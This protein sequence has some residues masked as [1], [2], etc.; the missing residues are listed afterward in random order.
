M[1]PAGERPS[2]TTVGLPGGI[3]HALPFDPAWCLVIED[4]T[5]S[6]GAAESQLCLADGTLGT[7]A[8]L[9]DD[10]DPSVPSVVVAGIYEPAEVVVERLMP[11][12]SWTSLPLVAGLPAGRRVLDLRDGTLRRD[13]EV[14]GQRLHSVRFA[15]LDL[16]GSAVLVAD[17]DPGLWA[18]DPAPEPLERV[19]ARWLS[20]FGGGVAA[21]IATTVRSPDGVPGG[22]TV[23]RMAAYVASARAVPTIG[24]AA[25]RLAGMAEAGPGGL[26]ARQ[27]EH[28]ARRWASCDVEVVGDV[29]MTRAMRASLFHLLGSARRR[30]EAA[31]GARGLTGPD[32]AGHV[33]WD[34]EAFVL[35]V[36]MA[37]DPPAARA[38]LEYRIRR[39]GP[40]RVRAAGEGRSGA[41]FPWESAHSG[42]DV[43]P[44]WGRN[45][46]GEVVPISTGDEEEHIT[47]MVALAAWR[48]AAWHGGWTFLE[49][50]GRPL[51]VDTAR[52]WSTRVRIDADG[53]GHI[54][55]VTGPDE[56]HEAVDDNVFTNLMARWNLQRGAD[57]IE[58]VGGDAD[59]ARR[60]RR[61]AGALVDGYDAA[62]GVYEQFDGYRRL[63]PLLATDLGTPPLNADTV[64]GREHLAASQVIKQADVL[65]AHFLAP[66]CAVPGSLAANLDYYLPRTAHGS[67]LSPAVH[68]T[69]LARVGRP[70][71]ALALLRTAAAVDFDDLTGSTAG[72]LHLANLGGMWQA[73]AHGFAG[74]TVTG[75]GDLLAI[76]PCLPDE[77]EEI[78]LGLRWRGRSLNLV[79]R[80]DG[81]H[82][83]CDAPVTVSVRGA[84]ERITPPG[85]WVR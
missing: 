36:L 79:C 19:S 16:P 42:E 67:S 80:H 78:R 47:A 53:T 22:V 7:R 59:E 38:A 18:G 48:Y 32:Y 56:Y 31:I 45:E 41:R 8:V 27:R 84:R 9:E 28:W 76:D 57:L 60:W 65:M 44:R 55:R 72:G 35:P 74:L 5:G 30:G 15:C 54:D 62:T 21:S 37:V 63:E 6:P 77:W 11:V 58:R 20:P 85:R 17:V 1:T 34:T 51:V 46:H 66:D 64:L 81:V 70:E 49:G 61:L 43:T 68:A 39:L 23:E 71:E 14:H 13:V 33:F 83:G 29:G 25:H 26:L 69:L 73:L 75:P 24:G 52:Y 82:V 2:G 3:G 4:G 40:A 50:A 12:E 10:A